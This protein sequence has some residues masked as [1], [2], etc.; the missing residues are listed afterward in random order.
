MSW[1]VDAAGFKTP[2]G[3][4]FIRVKSEDRVAYA[5]YSSFNNT[6]VEASN[7]L[8]AQ[9]MPFVGSDRMKALRERVEGIRE[10]P[11]L[12]I[13]E[14]VGWNGQ[15]FALPDGTVA[16][17]EGAS[18]VPIMFQARPGKTHREGTLSA[19]KNAIA[20]LEGQRVVTF[21]I[22]LPFLAPLLRFT[23]RLENFGFELVGPPASGKT[24]AQLGASSAMGGI[25]DAM[26]GRYWT[27]MDQTL[28]ALANVMESHADMLI[29]MD[30]ANLLAGGQLPSKQRAEL[31]GLAFKLSSGTTKGRYAGAEQK[32]WRLVYL[33]SSNEPLRKLL[34][35]SGGALAARDRLMTLD[36]T[37]RPFG[38]F[39][40]VPDRHA[41]ASA[42]ANHLKARW[43]EQHGTA[44]PAF[45]K[46]LVTAV[47]KDE[48]AVRTQIKA[49]VTEFQRRA[50]ID[51]N[52]GSEAR[53]SEA[54]GLVYAAGK[55]AQAYGVLPKALRCG[56]AAL[57]CYRMH[58]R[59]QLSFMPLHDRLNALL[60]HPDAV[61]APAS[62]PT[63][64]QIQALKSATIIVKE[65]DAG[66]ELAMLP[67]QIARY[68]PDW[69]DLK[70]TS[71]GGRWLER[72][73]RHLGTYRQLWP[74]APKKRWLVFRLPR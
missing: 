28:N 21:C 5:P 9:D 45:I 59:A 36:I 13:V 30:E 73:G 40:S 53:V 55:L 11:L 68:L 54:F 48:G 29:V 71:E 66:V 44:F 27:T 50:K 64:A 67:T 20:E 42:F 49:W 14:H 2:S 1:F 58:S 35:T 74:G 63:N 47:G 16:A 57:A 17:A 33:T 31:Q 4:R 34:D 41:S 43:A 38:V 46:K 61:C 37:G 18:T 52:K 15:V 70:R 12:D 69:Q 23:D 39:D 10:F 51:P 26:G 72:D 6:A 24:T 7:I 22:M 56:P 25:I 65:T 62:K 8:S 19:W 60:K 3:R 32:S